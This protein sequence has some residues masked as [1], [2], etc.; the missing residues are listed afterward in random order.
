MQLFISGK[1]VDSES[2]KCYESY[3]PRT[4]E[5]LTKV[6]RATPED[7]DKAVCAAR[8]AFDKG[9]WPRMKA[10]ER[11]MVLCHLATM[12]EVRRVWRVPDER[13]SDR[14]SLNI[15]TRNRAMPAQEEQEY[16]TQ[17]ECL[18]SGKTYAQVRLR[19]GETERLAH[20]SAATHR[21]LSPPDA[22]RSLSRTFPRPS[23]TFATLPAWWTRLRAGRFR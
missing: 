7:V 9:P 8:E 4:N 1:F 21:P 23:I 18:D 22:P 10:K 15:L 12:M 16:L 20:R 2:G 14:V 19:E 13:G 11:G 3:D 5:V 17:L 6:A